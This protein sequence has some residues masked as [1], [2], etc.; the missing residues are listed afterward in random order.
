MA[1][2]LKMSGYRTK[3]SDIWDPMTLHQLINAQQKIN[4]KKISEKDNFKYL[5]N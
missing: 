2:N 3:Q 1:C 5:K 4:K